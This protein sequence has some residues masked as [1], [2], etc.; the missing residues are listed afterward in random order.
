[1]IL[2]ILLL[3]A[4]SWV[5][6]SFAAATYDLSRGIFQNDQ[7]GWHYLW[8]LLQVLCIIAAFV[9]TCVLVWRYLP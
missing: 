7:S 5:F 3:L 6:R 1:M 4:A 8:A 9:L 2:S